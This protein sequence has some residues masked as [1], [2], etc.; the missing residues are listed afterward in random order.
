MKTKTM[1]MAGMILFAAMFATTANGQSVMYPKMHF[2]IRVGGTFTSSSLSNDLQGY[3]GEYKLKGKTFPTGGL[4]VDFRVASAPVYLET[5]A[6]YVNRSAVVDRGSY[7]SNL[8]A[9]TVQV[10]LLLSYHFYISDK[11]AVQPFAGGYASYGDAF[12]AG[13]RLGAGINYGRLYANIGYD[14]DLIDHSD[15]IGR[16]VKFKSPGLFTTIGFNFGGS[17]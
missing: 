10:P 17:R 8:D 2:G 15:R 3:D 14:I 4:A 6:Y 16:E 12:G 5:G 7:E 9:H 13:V 1:K 11:S